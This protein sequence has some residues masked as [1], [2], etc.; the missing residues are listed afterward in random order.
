MKKLISAIAVC[1]LAIGLIAVP[2]ALGVKST[3]LV[4]GTVSV[5]VTPVPLPD[6]TRTVGVTGNLA[7]SSSCRSGRTVHFFW[8]TNGVA[9]S[10]VG[11]AM[12][13]ANGDF[14]ATLPRPTDTSTSTSSATLRTTVDQVTRKVGSKKKG[15]KTKKGRAFECLS[16]TADVPV[17]LSAT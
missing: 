11:N 2:G 3:K 10:E 17:A 4:S 5:G 6:A 15:K 12:T 9:G 8:V 7:S 1:A 16:L 13:G 14:S